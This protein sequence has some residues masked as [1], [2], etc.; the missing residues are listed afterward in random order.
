MARLGVHGSPHSPHRTRVHWSPST[1]SEPK[2]SSSGPPKPNPAT[3]FTPVDEVK[4]VIPVLK[5]DSTA[6]SPSGK[7]SFRALGGD[8]SLWLLAGLKRRSERTAGQIRVEALKRARPQQEQEHQEEEEEQQQQ[9]PP[10]FIIQGPGSSQSQ[11]TESTLSSSTERRPAAWVYPDI[12]GPSNPGMSGTQNPK[13]ITEQP[14]NSKYSIKSE[15]ETRGPTKRELQTDPLIE[16]LNCAFITACCPCVAVSCPFICPQEYERAVVF[17]LGKLLPGGVRGPGVSFINPCFDEWK[18]VDLRIEAVDI[19]PQEVLTLDGVLVLVD[20][21][22]FF[23][24]RDAVSSC[25]DIGDFRLATI[26]MCE[27]TLRAVLGNFTLTDVLE[28]NSDIERQLKKTLAARTAA[29]GVDVTNLEIKNIRL[30]TAIVRSMS[31]EAE[32]QKLAL[33]KVLQAEGEEKSASY[34]AQA[35]DCLSDPSAVT[36]RSLKEL[37]FIAQRSRSITLFPFAL[38]EGFWT[39]DVG[40]KTGW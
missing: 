6:S 7:K 9:Q 1:T 8:L 34:L 35:S 5:R 27:G 20:A 33:A 38:S 28:R 18:T 40:A 12:L 37:T 10:L 36:L 19:Q 15:D 23:R 16:F 4:Q 3:F 24:V 31:T 14:R 39:W 2:L 13:A 26:R 25:C 30:P 32:T 17:R 22:V 11:S 21:V 29:W